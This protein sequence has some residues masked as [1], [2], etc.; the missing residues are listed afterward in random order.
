MEFHA[1]A[2]R[3]EKVRQK[4]AAMYARWRS[5]IVD[6]LTASRQAGRMREDADV[7]FMAIV[8]V[9]TVE[10]TILLHHLTPETVRLDDLVEPLTRT[11]AEWL[12]PR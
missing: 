7:Q 2:A 8:L 1:H 5:L 12:T 6:I 3:N 10:G 11:L 4:L 9:A